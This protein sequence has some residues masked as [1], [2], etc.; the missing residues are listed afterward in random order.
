MPVPMQRHHLTALQKW[1]N[2][3]TSAHR[4]CEAGEGGHNRRQNVCCSM[5]QNVAHMQ[6]KTIGP[7]VVQIS[8]ND[9]TG[10]ATHQH[11]QS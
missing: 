5:L 2:T 3:M 6:G 11:Y 8:S 10:F 7:G 1:Q 4:P 9:C